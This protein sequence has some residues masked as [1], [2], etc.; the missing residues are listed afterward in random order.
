MATLNKIEI[1]GTRITFS[2]TKR[3]AA[4]VWR[5][6]IVVLTDLISHLRFLL[7]RDTAQQSPVHN[8]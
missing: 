4:R 8:T 5:N 1:L 7:H 3:R 2:L 6:V